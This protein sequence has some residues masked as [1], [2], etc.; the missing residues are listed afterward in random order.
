LGSLG[1]S[2]VIPPPLRLPGRVITSA[3][4]VIDV[5]GIGQHDA[6]QEQACWHRRNGKQATDQPPPEP[7]EWDSK[8]EIKMLKSK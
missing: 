7:K 3:T 6:V 8:S 5:G 2:L 1:G 4:R